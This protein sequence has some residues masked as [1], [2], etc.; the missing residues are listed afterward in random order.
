VLHLDRLNRSL[1]ILL[2]PYNKVFTKNYFL[3]IN[4]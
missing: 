2:C 1:Q 3:L 4:L